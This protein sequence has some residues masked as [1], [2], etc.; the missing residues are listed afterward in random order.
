[1]E[2]SPKDECHRGVYWLVAGV[3]FLLLM[4]GMWWSRRPSEEGTHDAEPPFVALIPLIGVGHLT[5]ARA[6]HT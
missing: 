2:R 5:R 3:L 1:M 4:L 6:R